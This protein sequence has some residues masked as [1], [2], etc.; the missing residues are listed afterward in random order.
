MFTELKRIAKLLVAT[1]GKDINGMIIDFFMKN[2]K[3]DD[4]DI[5][6]LAEKLGLD[7][8]EFEGRIYGIL[9]GFLHQ[10]KS[11]GKNFSTDIPDK[12]LYD[13]AV[14]IE[15]EH[16]I[17]PALAKKIVMDHVAESGWGYYTALID[18]EKKLKG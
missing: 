3:V 16:T 4:N 5:H 1:D 6:A 14:E 12:A 18:M 2:E 15:M 13:K 8:H 17:I 10:G 11:K 9:S 7:P